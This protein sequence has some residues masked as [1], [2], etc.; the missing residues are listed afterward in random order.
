VNGIGEKKGGLGVEAK[1]DSSREKSEKL[2]GDV[3][4]YNIF[5]IFV[6]QALDYTLM[7]A[8]VSCCGR[9]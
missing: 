8:E 2:E 6:L 3:I 5:K 7:E 9:V 4:L 1:E